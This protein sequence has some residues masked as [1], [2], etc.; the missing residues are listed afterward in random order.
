VYQDTEACVWQTILLESHLTESHSLSHSRDGNAE[1]C[2]ILQNTATHCNTLLHAATHCNTLQHTAAH[3]N[4]L[5]HTATHCTTLQHTAAH[6]SLALSKSIPNTPTHYQA[7]ACS[8][9]LS[10]THPHTGDEGYRQRA[11]RAPDTRSSPACAAD[12]QT[13]NLQHIQL[14]QYTQQRPQPQRE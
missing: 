14:L 7:L 9:F 12:A 3:C 13:L 1:H 8:L 11:P 6:G 4:T 5:Q 10:H 2:N